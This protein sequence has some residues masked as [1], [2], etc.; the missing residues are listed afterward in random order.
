MPYMGDAFTQSFESVIQRINFYGML[1]G[2]GAAAPVYPTNVPS[3]TSSK[4]FMQKST[5]VISSVANDT[6]RTGTGAYT[7]KLRLAAAGS[8]GLPPLLLDVSLNV[9]GPNGTW[10]TVSDYNPSTGVLTFLT[11][12]AGGSAADLQAT[13]FLHFVFAFQNTLPFT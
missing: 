1:Q 8:I 12:A 13:E 11:F 3:T 10:S 9:W 6:V 7:T 4:G 2:A 5:N